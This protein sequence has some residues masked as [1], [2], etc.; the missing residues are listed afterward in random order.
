LIPIY[1]NVVSS[2]EDL[3]P[4]TKRGEGGIGSTGK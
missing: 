2:I 4:V 1:V 3:G